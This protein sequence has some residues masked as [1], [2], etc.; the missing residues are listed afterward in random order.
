MRFT[1]TFITTYWSDS[2]VAL[3][4]I[5][6]DS[7]RWQTFVKNRVNKIQEVSSPDWWRHCPGTQN[8]SDL[9]SRGATAGD[10]INSD[11]WWKGPP[12]LT[13]DES[14]WPSSQEK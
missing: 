12:W 6:G 9:A 13:E 5:K 3:G 1:T 2:K 10:L 8:P 14:N 4:W 11:L 7:S